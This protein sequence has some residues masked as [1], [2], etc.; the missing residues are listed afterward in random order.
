MHLLIF[1]FFDFLPFLVFQTI[2]SERVIVLNTS[3]SPKMIIK[4]F[5]GFFQGKVKFDL[6]VTTIPPRSI[7]DFKILVEGATLN[8]I[9]IKNQPYV[10]SKKV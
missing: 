2:L 3:A 5:S 1:F 6:T 9:V 8:H 10:I 4:Y 7:M